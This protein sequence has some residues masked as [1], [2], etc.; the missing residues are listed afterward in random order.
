M[1]SELFYRIAIQYLT[2]YR[3]GA[4]REMLRLSGSAGNIF[5]SPEL[6]TK[7]VSNRYKNKPLPTITKEI[8]RQVEHELRQMEKNGISYCFYTDE[9]YPFRLRGCAD[10]PIGFFYKGEASIFQHPHIIAMVGTRN[11]SDYGRQC[12]RKIVRELGETNLATISGLAYGIDTEAHSRSLEHG[13]PTIAVMGCGLGTIYPSQNATIA[14]RI[15]E[16]GG[17]WISEYGYDTPPDRNNFPKRNRII[18]GMADAVLVVETGYKGGSIITAYIAQSYNRD[19][20]AIPGSIF[21]SQN[22]GC[23]NLIHK[24]IAALVTS[25]HEIISLMNWEK[26]GV[27]QQMQ[28][29]ATLDETEQAVTEI[30]RQGKKVTIDIITEKMNGMSPSKLAGILLGLELKGVIESRPGKSYSLSF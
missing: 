29:F 4:I 10:A 19:V 11:A 6:W 8:E 9:N 21:T 7:K 22:D 3:A 27:Q 14:S 15:L 2:D 18:A 12:V 30:I 13:I 24:N 25:G 1:Y 23:H 5:K 26:T 28:L 17:V 20:F 16:N